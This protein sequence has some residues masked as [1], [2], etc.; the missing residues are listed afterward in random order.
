VGNNDFREVVSAGD[1][2]NGCGTAQEEERSG[3]PHW[4]D[5]EKGALPP[6]AL[7]L[8]DSRCCLSH[9]LVPVERESGDYRTWL[10]KKTHGREGRGKKRRKEKKNKGKK[11]G[12]KEKEMKK[13]KKKLT[14]KTPPA[15]GTSRKLN[16]LVQNH[17]QPSHFVLYLTD[18][19]TNT[20]GSGT[21]G[22]EILKQWHRRDDNFSRGKSRI[23]ITFRGTEGILSFFNQF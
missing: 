18:V 21:E 19:R 12:K 7:H 9:P 23:S 8:P 14:K 13:R 3:D 17:G 20:H 15:D 11:K 4:G 6:L 2:N 16:A 1:G 10:D 22:R 5:D